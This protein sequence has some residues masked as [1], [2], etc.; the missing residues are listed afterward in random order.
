VDAPALPDLRWDSAEPFATWFTRDS[1]ALKHAAPS[2]SSDVT[3]P[4]LP[5]S[6]EIEVSG[7]KATSFNP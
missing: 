1:Q 5:F 3:M 4:A 2:P 6:E 7:A